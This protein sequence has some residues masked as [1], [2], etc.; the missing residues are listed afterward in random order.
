MKNYD[1]T[2][3]INQH[4]ITRFNKRYRA[5][6]NIFRLRNLFMKLIVSSSKLPYIAPPKSILLANGAHIGDVVISTSLLPILKHAFPGIKVGFLMGSWSKMVL[7][8]HPLVDRVHVIDHWFASRESKPMCYKILNY[9]QQR[10]DVIH[11]IKKE[12]Y[13]VAVDLRLWFPDLTGVLYEAKIP[14]RIGYDRLGSAPLLTHVLNFRPGRKHEAIWQ[15]ELLRFLPIAEE[16]YAFQRQSLPPGDVKC[17]AEVKALLG[18]D[19]KRYRILH[20]GSSQQNREWPKANWQALTQRIL[21]ENCLLVFTG[22]GQYEKHLILEIIDG[23]P[24]CLDVCNKLSWD[25]L[26]ELVKGAELVYCVETSVGHIAAAVGTPG[27]ALYGGTVDPS[28]W[29]P[30]SDQCVLAYAPLACSPCF[31]KKGCKTMDCL[32]ELSVDAVFEAGKKAL[33]KA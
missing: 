28:H 5:Q 4:I 25:G 11:E 3:E 21:Q 13:D 2:C 12:H 8:N 7:E 6:T 17:K 20:V 29:K 26:V 23:V 31:R 10:R 1:H 9:L 18:G 15:A 19:S 32:R 24:N 14:Y 16:S 33:A 27:V 30:Y 22:K